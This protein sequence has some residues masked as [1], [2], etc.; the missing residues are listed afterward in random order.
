MKRGVFF[1]LV[2]CSLYS[3]DTRAYLNN[4]IAVST[5]VFNVHRKEKDVVYQFQYYYPYRY[6]RLHFF[7]GVMFNNNH[8]A[9]FFTGF[10]WKIN[11]FRNF[12]IFPTFAP[13]LY[14]RGDSKSLGFPLEFRSCLGF[15]GEIAPN[16]SLGAQFFHLSNAGIG[17]HNPGTNC[18]VLTLSFS[19][20]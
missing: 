14:S 8:A 5:G 18:L 20:N 12:Y 4:G 2:L 13:G 19:F 11:L 1:V 17:S 16:L 10:G 3:A 6:K 9:Y 7:S 15:G